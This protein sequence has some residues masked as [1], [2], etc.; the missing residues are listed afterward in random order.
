MRAGRT[1]PAEAQ[2]VGDHGQ[3]LL[4]SLRFFLRIYCK[5]QQTVTG[6][7]RRRLNA[8]AALRAVQTSQMDTHA[9]THA[10]LAS[11]TFLLMS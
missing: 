2:V 9:D 4:F 11:C 3:V 10:S 1:C 8:P 6:G 5:Y 7:P